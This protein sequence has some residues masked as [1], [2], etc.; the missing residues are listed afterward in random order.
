MCIGGDMKDEYDFSNAERGKFYR[1]D[2]RLIPP[3]AAGTGGAGFSRDQ[4]QEAR[5]DGQSTGQSVAEKRHRI[6]SGCRW[7]KAPIG[8][9]RS[10][11]YSRSRGF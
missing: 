2:L 4:R 1:P 9:L 6:D 5:H 10:A 3:R 7:L 8:T 11:P